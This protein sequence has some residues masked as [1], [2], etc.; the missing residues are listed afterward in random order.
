MKLECTNHQTWIIND[1]PRI[2]ITV[3]EGGQALVGDLK[4]EGVEERGWVVQNGDVCEVH[5]AHRLEPE[6]DSAVFGWEW[7]LSRDWMSLIEEGKSP[8]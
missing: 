8:E 1:I 6:Q 4:L 7:G 2:K 5:C 3:F